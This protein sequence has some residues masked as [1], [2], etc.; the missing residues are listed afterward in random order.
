MIAYDLETTRIAA[1]TPKPLYLT[2]FCDEWKCSIRV[3]S[4]AH[5]F[6]ILETRFFIPEFVGAR[7][8][9][10]NA[11]NFDV[12][13]IGLAVL[14]CERYIIRPYLTRSKSLR[15]LKVFLRDDPKQSWEFL[16]G[17]AMTGL[18][19]TALRKLDDFL[20]VFASEHRKHT[21]EDG[22]PDFEGGENFNPLN[23]RHVAYA[24]RDSEGL[25]RGLHA[26]EVIT[27]E[28][29]KMPLQ[30]TIGNM[31]IKIFQ[32]HM[33]A[34]ATVW[35]PNLA[36]LRAIRDY[37]M[38]GGF[39]YCVERFEGPVW[40]YDL[41][42]A[43]A[44][45][46]RDCLL[47]S[48]TCIHSRSVHPYAQTGIYRVRAHNAR[49]KIPFYYRSLDRLPVFGVSEIAE[50][51]LTS[52]E[53]TQLQREGWSVEVLEGFFWDEAFRMREYVDKLEGLRVNAP[54]GPGG[55]QGLI[56]KCIGNN[57]YGKTVE[58]LDGIEL[59]MANECPDGFHEYQSEDD[60]VRHLW[61]KFGK[62]VLRE[63]HQPQ[64]GAFI[65]AHV[66]MVVRRAALLAPDAWKYADTDCVMFDQAVALPV[67]PGRYGM[68][69]LEAAGEPYLLIGKKVYTDMD[70]A[71]PIAER[72]RHAKG[73]NVRRLTDA[74]FVAWHKGAWTDADTGEILIS[75]RQKQVQRQNFVKAM[76]GADMF[77]EHTKVGQRSVAV[78]TR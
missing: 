32:S 56:M 74:D 13:F 53:I 55:A 7:F 19:S 31:G 37:V 10:W 52:I 67:D 72:V 46:M 71:A 38:R 22:A 14:T 58:Q 50:T 17:L 47:P 59:V 28:H 24:E 15:G 21:I 26:F 33:P 51:W 20:K 36:A 45:A 69:K 6:E 29:F 9:G 2:A 64:L 75:P 8:V 61:F 5:L 57:S 12:F 49:N 48:G 63:Y 35:E 70:Y 27:V 77:I 40:K 4:I 62:P 3:N 42:Q 44:A 60:T 73:M 78:S 68:W 65:T 1:G 41:N 54:G 18:G 43:Y 11:N 23:A 30:P 66:R 76:T 39:C 34:D 16:D 25:Y